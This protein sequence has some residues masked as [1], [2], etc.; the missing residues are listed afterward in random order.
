MTG[1]QR[2]DRKKAGFRRLAA[3]G[4]GLVVAL[5]LIAAGVTWLVAK[6][7]PQAAHSASPAA[8]TG[9]RPV[10]NHAGSQSSPAASSAA[11]MP[12]IPAAALAAHHVRVCGNS[13]I[14]GG[15]PSARPAGA[16]SVPAGDNSRVNFR[17][18]HETYWFAPGIHTLGSGKYSQI[19]PGP[20]S[21][22]V[23]APGAVL[24]GRQVNNYAFT[25]NAPDVTIS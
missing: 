3:V 16:V 9:T 24:D 25:G 14:L 12:A 18:P 2:S 1:D 8:D 17:R 7:S 10:T 20:G 6:S 5:A 13:R 23:G 11:V 21:A 4:V 19:Q 22:F 15:G